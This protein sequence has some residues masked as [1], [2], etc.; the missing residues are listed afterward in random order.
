MEA[1]NFKSM[2]DPE[3]KGISIQANPKYIKIYVYIL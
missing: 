2:F 1:V 3:G